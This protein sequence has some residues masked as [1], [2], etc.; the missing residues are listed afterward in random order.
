MRAKRRR[1]TG[2]HHHRPRRACSCT[3]SELRVAATFHGSGASC[4][5]WGARVSARVQTLGPWPDGRRGCRPAGVTGLQQPAPRP[6]FTASAARRLA[7]ARAVGR[8][9]RLQCAPALTPGCC[10]RS[11]ARRFDPHPPLPVFTQCGRTPN[12]LRAVH[13]LFSVAV[14][15]LGQRPHK[16][17]K[18]NP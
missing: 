10:V 7:R 13:G 1:N 14:E 9:A 17:G 5:R 16:T 18:Q 4:W 8:A 11:P 15:S 3:R 12:A 6:W 2:P